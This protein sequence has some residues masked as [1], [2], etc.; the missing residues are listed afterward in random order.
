MNKGSESGDEKAKM[1][2]KKCKRDKSDNKR[3]K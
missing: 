3:V 2:V 1:M